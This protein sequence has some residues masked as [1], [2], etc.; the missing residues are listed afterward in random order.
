MRLWLVL[1]MDYLS[2]DYMQGQ[3][4]PGMV[5]HDLV[6]TCLSSRVHLVWGH[7][8]LRGASP[9]SRD[10]TGDHVTLRGSRDTT[11]SHV[12]P[13]DTMEVT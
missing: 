4:T 10:T 9:G 12:I 11:G 2:A 6:E 5:I 7:V 3:R 1:A 13:R 8:T